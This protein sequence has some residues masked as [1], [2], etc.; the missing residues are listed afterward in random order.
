M[1]RSP[2]PR[3]WP[4]LAALAAG[5]LPAV[6]AAPTYYVNLAVL[7]LVYSLLAMSLN[8]LMGYV[9]LTSFGHAAFFGTAAYAAGILSLRHGAAF[10]PAAAAGV[11]AG[12]LLGA[13]YGLLVS[14]SRGV[15]FL[16]ITLA[17]GQ[18]T[19]GL[20]LRWVSM[21]GGDNGLPGIARPALWVGWPL[22]DVRG[23]YLFA[24]IVVGVCVALLALVVASPFGYALRGIRESPSRMRT[25]GYPVWGYAYA[26]FVLSA[27][28]A[29]VAGVL[30]VYYN[31]FVSHQ[32][33]QIAVSAQVALMVIVGGAGSFWGPAAGAT[34]LVFMQNLLSSITQRWMTV[35]GLL[36][37][38]VV[39]YQPSGLAGLVGRMRRRCPGPAAERA[40][41]PA[42][43][44]TA[45]EES[46]WDR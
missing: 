26:A 44:P 28:F 13:A 27:L 2:A 16:L 7:A 1:R 5:A 46:G 11:A 42:T 12:T 34:L 25:L 8:L 21:T 14:G 23:Y 6:V 15:Y 33:M 29:S 20:T 19:W 4:I 40:A 41:E 37:I 30:Y 31:G 36:Y 24:L 22:D 9:G 32:N 38:V 3:A 18:V 10:W 35:L 39:L 45:G 17:L 43:L